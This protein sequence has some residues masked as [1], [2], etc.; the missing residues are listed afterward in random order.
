MKIRVEF[1]YSDETRVIEKDSA[2][3]TFNYSLGVKYRLLH[4]VNSKPELGTFL[5]NYVDTA[6]TLQEVKIYCDGVI[7]KRVQF[8]GIESAMYRCNVNEEGKL[9]EYIEVQYKL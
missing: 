2:Y 5:E 6:K 9:N 7:F 3:L 1:L 8:T 4:V